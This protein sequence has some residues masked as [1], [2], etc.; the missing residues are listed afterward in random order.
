MGCPH[1][2]F[3]VCMVRLV[4]STKRDEYSPSPTRKYFTTMSLVL[5]VFATFLLLGYELGQVVDFERD[6]VKLS[7]NTQKIDHVSSSQQQQQMQE[8]LMVALQEEVD[9]LKLKVDILESGTAG[10]YAYGA[11]IT[12]G[13]TANMARLAIAT[14]FSANHKLEAVAM[15]KA[16]IASG[17][18]G[19][20]YAFL[21]PEPGAKPNWVD[22]L[23][24]EIV[25]MPLSVN[26]I[27]FPITDSLKTYCFK[28]KAMASFFNRNDQLPLDSR[29]NVVMWADASTRYWQNPLVWANVSYMIIVWISTSIFCFYE[30]EYLTN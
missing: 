2:A 4:A 12:H 18:T 16:L 22:D 6:A 21:M 13:H 19:T 17:F 25:N 8:M 28:P 14:A 27:E 20:V 1:R 11:N 23:K 10:Q 29:A 26:L 15:L 3:S 7:S 24:H 30:Y 5:V 9:M